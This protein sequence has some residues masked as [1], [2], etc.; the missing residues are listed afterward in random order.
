MRLVL[1]PHLA[2]SIS[3]T[4]SATGKGLELLTAGLPKDSATYTTTQLTIPTHKQLGPSGYVFALLKQVFGRVDMTCVERAESLEYTLCGQSEVVAEAATLIRFMASLPDKE[5]GMLY[6]LHPRLTSSPELVTRL[7]NTA[8]QITRTEV[9]CLDSS[10]TEACKF[11]FVPGLCG[12]NHHF[13]LQKHLNILVE[14]LEDVESNTPIVVELEEEE[15][16]RGAVTRYTP[17]EMLEI[18]KLCT[19]PLPV[20]AKQVTLPILVLNSGA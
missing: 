19:V 17:E 13:K 3:G 5:Y 2:T 6:K 8:Q 4:K 20:L 11:L 9:H 16:R 10:K 18:R 1:L 14:R 15:E 7:I 12:Q